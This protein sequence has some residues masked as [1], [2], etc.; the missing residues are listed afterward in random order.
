MHAVSSKYTL[1]I[2]VDCFS[3]MNS[4]PGV[5]MFSMN[6]SVCPALLS[7][8][9]SLNLALLAWT[10]GVTLLWLFAEMSLVL[11]LAICGG[12]KPLL[13]YVCNLYKSMLL[14]KKLIC[15]NKFN[16]H[17]SRVA[18]VLR[19]LVKVKKVLFPIIAF[20]SHGV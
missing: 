17:R 13:L 10:R 5:S 19:N 1:L 14:K 4:S 6:C 16:S 18:R 3:C 20:F 8:V 7:V 15:G 9:M 11:L 12:S 2:N